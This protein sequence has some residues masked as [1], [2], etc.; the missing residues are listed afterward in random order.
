MSH[1][2]TRTIFAAA[3][4][5]VTG[6]PC[7][8]ETLNLAAALKGS[9]ET[10]PNTAAGTGALTGTYD[11]DTK[12]LTW[13]VTYSGLTGPATAA[14]FHGPRRPWQG[15]AGRSSGDRCR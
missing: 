9:E 6:V 1:F 4:L 10:P 5:F 12:K 14:H 13:S 11:T 2:S 15:G 3:A 8:A 7:F